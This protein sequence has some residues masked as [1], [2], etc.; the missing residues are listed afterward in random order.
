MESTA[1][2]LFPRSG[3]TAPI[4]DPLVGLKRRNVR[5]R[6]LIRSLPIQSKFL[7]VLFFPSEQKKAQSK[8]RANRKIKFDPRCVVQLLSS[9]Q[10]FCILFWARKNLSIHLFF[11]SELHARVDA[12]HFD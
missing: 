2:C 9:L 12:G 3:V 4:A 6:M 5:D 1:A 8:T 10:C 11:F 7:S